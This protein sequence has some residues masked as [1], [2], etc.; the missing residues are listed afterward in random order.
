MEVAVVV[1]E[2]RD[3]LFF[4]GRGERECGMVLVVFFVVGMEKVMDDS[5]TGCR[6]SEVEI[7]IILR[8]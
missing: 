3:V 6:E 5:V 7:C 8:T 4:V 1:E 2:K